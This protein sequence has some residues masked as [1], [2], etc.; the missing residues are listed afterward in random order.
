MRVVHSVRVPAD[1][2]A[3]QRAQADA[4]MTDWVYLA[5]ANATLFTAGLGC[6][7]H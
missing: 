6:E 2:A 4:A 1:D 3:G 7:V 5:R